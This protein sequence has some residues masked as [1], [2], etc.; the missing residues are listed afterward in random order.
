MKASGSYW[1]RWTC[2]LLLI[3][4]LAAWLVRWRTPQRPSF[5][6]ITL[7]TTRAD[8]LGCYGHAEAR[9]PT[10]DALA[11]SGAQFRRAFATAPLTLPSHATLLTGLY[12]PEHGLRTNG[13]GRLHAEVPTLAQT[14][15][16]A[17]YRTGAFVGAFVLDS[18]FGLD[19]GFAVYDDDLSQSRRTDDPL[20]RER[21]G[22]AVVDRALAW[23]QTDDAPFLC[24]V[25]LYDPHFPYQTHSDHFGAQFDDRPY[26]AEIAY[27][28]RQIQRLVEFL[29][30]QH[31]TD[32]TLVMVVGDHGEGLGDHHETMHGYM[33]YNSTLHVPWLVKWPGRIP[34]GAVIEEPV[35][36]VDLMPTALDCLSLPPPPDTT[37]QSLKPAFD[38]L[39]ITPSVCYA[40]TDDPRLDNRWCGLQTLITPE[41]KYIRTARPELFRFPDDAAEQHDLAQVEADRVQEL[42]RELLDF[43]AGLKPRKTDLAALSSR[44]VRILSSLGY[45]AGQAA[46][47][48][49]GDL[50]GHD[51][52]DMVLH[53]N[54]V[55][56]AT[57]LMEHGRAAEAEPLL[58]ETV[59]AVPDYTAAWGNLGRC[60][61]QQRRFDDAR[62][63][64][65]RVLELDPENTSALLNL[66]AADLA[67]N[68]RQAA[69]E[70]LQ[71][72]LELDPQS[73][74]AHYYLAG[75]SLQSGDARRARSEL[76][77][78]I[79]I[80]PEHVLSLT[81]LGDLH[82]EEGE[83]VRAC[84]YYSA[85]SR[86]D[87]YAP[88]PYV[89]RGI[90]LGQLG[91]L[92]EAV[93]CFLQGLTYQPDA[94]LLHS[95]LGFALEQQR[96][97]GEA[98][99]HYEAALAVTPDEPQALVRLPLLLSAAP[100]D[101]LR[102]GPR[103]LELAQR[104][105]T[106]SGGASA[107]AYDALAAACAETGRFDEAEAAIRQAQR[108]GNPTT[109]DWQRLEARGRLYHA[110]Q[111]LRLPPPR[112]GP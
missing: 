98:I 52:K 80:D 47:A 16:Q 94:P 91:R 74:D 33:L 85:A 95:N 27:V 21:P 36:L 55:V 8:R 51:I 23:L 107:D 9:T 72:V 86:V 37:G 30:A 103:A 71:R 92:D 101:A 90:A 1:L 66:A 105:V 32:N 40:E 63:S 25:H 76:Q 56:E 96:R 112:G 73:A 84:E 50:A 42:D 13:K 31:L 100:N 18:K 68:R 75:V 65:H 104:A 11:S 34:A 35:S 54:R 4:A 43:L 79:A 46:A 110:Q 38:R 62:Q 58:R 17:G 88:G 24:W 93:A 26:D 70:R 19:R 48:P 61:A 108:A 45:T 83:F 15:Q 106:L 53:F 41:W 77:R 69:A 99:A 28:D 12:P 82:F 20:H 5:L 29:D 64:Y 44:D 39:P 14:L 2:G 10:L 87:P 6:L 22:S 67:E 7:D 111:T 3:A 57:H 97:Y 81:Q 109:E 89:N 102:N 78:A 59:D 60:L 49:L